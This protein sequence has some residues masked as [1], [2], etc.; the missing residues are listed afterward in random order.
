V[1]STDCE[2]ERLAEYGVNVVRLGFMWSGYNPAPGV[3]NQTYMSLVKTIVARLN[4]QGI[5]VFMDMHQDGLSSKFCLYDGIPLWV[6]NKSSVKIAKRAFPWPLNATAKRCS[7]GWQSN[8]ITAAACTCYQDI[9][10]NNYG[11]LDDLVAFWKRAAAELKDLPGVLVRQGFRC[12]R[13]VF[14]E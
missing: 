1:N 8:V 10:D 2:A 12:V 13:I 14:L 5:Y 6:A 9:Y 4:N 7:W 3:F 11:M